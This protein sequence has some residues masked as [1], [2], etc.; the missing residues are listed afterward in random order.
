MQ[1]KEHNN[2]AGKR[3]EEAAV[4]HQKLPNRAG[5]SAEGDEHD[6][7]AD[8]E[9]Q[10][11]SEQAATGRFSLAQLLHSDAGEHGDIAGHQ[12]QDTRGKKR[13]QSRQKR[14][15]YGYL[16]GSIISQIGSGAERRRRGY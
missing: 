8:Y 7:K 3:R 16:H 4:S 1:P 11:G 14:S 13:N 12:R 15:E 6:G 9:G 10:R 2:R 5:R